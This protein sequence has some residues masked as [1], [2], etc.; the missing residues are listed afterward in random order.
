MKIFLPRTFG[1]SYS[2]NTTQVIQNRYTFTGREKSAVGG[3]PMSYR[4]RT[5][6]S[7]LGR[8]GHRDP[9]GYN[10]NPMGN[11]YDYVDGSPAIYVDP[12]GLASFSVNIPQIDSGRL[13]FLL[14]WARIKLKG[15]WN[16]SITPDATKASCPTKLPG[17]PTPIKPIANVGRYGIIGID[18]KVGAQGSNFKM[19]AGMKFGVSTSGDNMLAQILNLSVDKGTY[20][21]IAVD[22]QYWFKGFKYENKTYAC[23][24]VSYQVEADFDVTVGGYTTRA[25]A[26]ALV[27]GAVIEPTPLG[28]AALA[29]A[30]A[31]LVIA[32]PMFG[33]IPE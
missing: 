3:A 5:Y 24:C 2:P 20:Q 6:S 1:S 9:A 4:N 22:L 32:P 10:A 8:F 30:A 18:A 31:A 26:A 27:A 13:D 29:S 25:L 15:K 33:N 16:M 19:I 23:A 28:E 12:Y 14:L 21:D 17:S 7:G 11:L